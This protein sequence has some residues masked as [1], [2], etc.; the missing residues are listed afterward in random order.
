MNLREK[1]FLFSRLKSEFILWVI[2]RG[3]D[4]V[5]GE[6]LRTKQQA[7]WN[8]EKGLGIAN[9]LHT[10][11]LAVDLEFLK[12]GTWPR[13]NNQDHDEHFESFAKKWD[14]LHYLCRSGYSFN[15]PYHFSITH[16]GV[17]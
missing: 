9:S 3:Y 1:Q 12:D 2:A 7:L 15:D 16:G 17:S 11:A 14:S 4:V 6:V 8:R 10:K 5:T 13:G